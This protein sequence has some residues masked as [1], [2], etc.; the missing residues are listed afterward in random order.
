MEECERLVSYSETGD[1]SLLQRPCTRDAGG[2]VSFA[3]EHMTA[4]W[5]ERQSKGTWDTGESERPQ[6]QFRVSRSSA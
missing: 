5:N 3:D 4:E 6:A 1:Q 2:E